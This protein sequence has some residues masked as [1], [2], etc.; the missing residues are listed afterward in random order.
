M[1]CLAYV[2]HY[3]ASRYKIVNDV[4]D[5]LNTRFFFVFIFTFY[6]KSEKKKQNFI[7]SVS[8]RCQPHMHIHMYFV[9]CHLY[10]PLVL[11]LCHHSHGYKTN[12]FNQVLFFSIY[13]VSV[14][15]IFA[16]VDDEAFRSVIMSKG[17]SKLMKNKKGFEFK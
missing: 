15:F 4:C 17:S 14:I 12:H 8:T 9:L 3:V 13:F 5:G 6:Y 2:L 11:L 16:C 1:H 10:F 7:F